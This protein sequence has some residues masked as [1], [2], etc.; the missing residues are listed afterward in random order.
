MLKNKFH[1]SQHLVD[2][3]ATNNNNLNKI[4]NDLK[5]DK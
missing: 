4:L 2:S 5:T 1:L 3:E